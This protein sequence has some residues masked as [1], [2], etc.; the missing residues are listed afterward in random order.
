M[1]MMNN[2]VMRPVDNSFEILRHDPIEDLTN[3]TDYLTPDCEDFIEE[4]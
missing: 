4:I 1:P 3:S 2:Y